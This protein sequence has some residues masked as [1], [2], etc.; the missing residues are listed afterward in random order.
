[1]WPPGDGGEL[2][3][4]VSAFP[5]LLFS[6]VLLTNQPML[7][8]DCFWYGEVLCDGAVVIVSRRNNTYQKIRYWSHLLNTSQ[9]LF[10]ISINFRISIVGGLS[11]AAQTREWES[12]PGAGRRLS[13]TPD[14]SHSY[15][16]SRVLLRYKL[17]WNIK[18]FSPLS[19]VT[20][21]PQFIKRR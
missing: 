8:S 1:M 4:N 3:G 11:R 12:A 7:F 20:L 14:L 9:K 13:M 21:A 10:L 6:W 17:N 15:S 19:E 5:I 16:L 2:E 18:L